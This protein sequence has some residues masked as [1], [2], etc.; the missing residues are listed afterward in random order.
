MAKIEQDA[1]APNESC[2]AHINVKRFQVGT[3]CKVFEEQW[4]CA[5]CGT[6]FYHLPDFFPGKIEIMEPVRTLRD[7]FAM[8]AM[9]GDWASQSEGIGQITDR[10]AETHSVW[11][12][13]RAR[14]Y[15]FMAD[16]MMKARNG[17]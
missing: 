1:K 5:D 17:D 3:D 4:R 8:A 6:P 9:S 2:C 11:F 15:Y 12:L 14:T 10:M 7:E 13:E 16:S